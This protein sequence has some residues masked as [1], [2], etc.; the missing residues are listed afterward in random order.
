MKKFIQSII[1]WYMF[2]F[3][4]NGHVKGDEAS[5]IFEMLAESNEFN[6]L[7]IIGF[8]ACIYSDTLTII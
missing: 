1:P 8:P 5:N 7:Y 6:N 2:F 3:F 4:Q